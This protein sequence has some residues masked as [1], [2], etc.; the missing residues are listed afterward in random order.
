[1]LKEKEHQYV[2]FTTA[3]PLPVAKNKKSLYRVSVLLYVYAT[4]LI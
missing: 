2:K 4:V 1:M 3:G